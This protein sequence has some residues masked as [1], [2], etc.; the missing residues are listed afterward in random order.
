MMRTSY[1]YYFDEM[2]HDDDNACLHELDQ[3]V[4]LS[5]LVLPVTISIIVC[6][7][8]QTMIENGHWK[9]WIFFFNVPVHVLYFYVMIFKNFFIF[10]PTHSVPGSMNDD[11]DTRCKDKMSTLNFKASFK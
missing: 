5:I 11:D 8:L 6:F 9:Y 3:H 1:W 4:T 7:G 2:T 10:N